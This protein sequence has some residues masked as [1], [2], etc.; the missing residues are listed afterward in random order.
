MF[1]LNKAHLKR[2]MQE[3]KLDY[4]D[5]QSIQYVLTKSRVILIDLYDHRILIDSCLK[6]VKNK[7]ELPSTEFS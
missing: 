1:N 2:S 3:G 7:N 5:N 6:H 4:H